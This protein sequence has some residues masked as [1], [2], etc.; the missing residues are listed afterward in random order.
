MCN[1]IGTLMCFGVCKL[2]IAFRNVY[3][4][5]NCNAKGEPVDSDAMYAVVMTQ[6]RHRVTVS[7]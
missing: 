4:F 2:C 6:T 1:D 7:A 3:G 5:V